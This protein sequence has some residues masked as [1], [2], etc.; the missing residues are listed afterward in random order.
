M[1]KKKI[2]KISLYGGPGLGKSTTGAWLFAEL[3]MRGLDVEFIPEYVKNWA[4]IRRS[5]RSWDQPYLLAKQ[6]HN[7]DIVMRD[8]ETVAIAECPLFLSVCYARKYKSKGW[9]ECVALCKSFDEHYPALN[10]LLQRGDCPYKELGRF[11]NYKEAL[12]MDRAI[13]AGM[14]EFGIEYVKVKYN[15]R[16]TLLNLVLDTMKVKRKKSSK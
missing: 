16:E 4:Y 9:K 13:E 12:M 2:R 10:I 7:E 15:D 1:K 5:P 6:M 14:K 11:Q 3:K 8:T